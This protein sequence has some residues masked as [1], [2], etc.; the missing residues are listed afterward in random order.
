MSSSD[1]SGAL[2][3]VPR[4]LVEPV[5][6][7]AGLALFGDEAGVLE[8]AQMP[9]HARLGRAEDA[10]ELG[11]VEAIL[12]EHAQQPEA[13]G[14]AEEA[15]EGGGALHTSINLHILIRVVNARVPASRKSSPAA[16]EKRHGRERQ[17]EMCPVSPEMCIGRTILRSRLQK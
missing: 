14:V 9:R 2:T 4:I 11:D 5:V 1:Q 3:V 6:D 12:G 17:R 7:E 16:Q 13:G 10:R 15:E 8:Q